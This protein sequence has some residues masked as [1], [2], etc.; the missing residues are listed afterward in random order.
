MHTRRDINLDTNETVQIQEFLRD[1]SKQ[2]LGDKSACS[3]ISDPPYTNWPTLGVTYQ[4]YMT[5]WYPLCDEEW[6][7]KFIG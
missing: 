1:D 5:Y 7:S 3:T 4:I 2:N 6:N